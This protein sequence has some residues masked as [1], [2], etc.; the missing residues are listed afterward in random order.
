MGHLVQLGP[1]HQV[2]GDGWGVPLEKVC[3]VGCKVLLQLG[4][5][6]LALLDARLY[7][8]VVVEEEL[9]DENLRR[10]QLARVGVVPVQP[11]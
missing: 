10:G 1:D 5:D 8:G 9:G 7:R 3:A 2:I 6:G 4:E 11:V